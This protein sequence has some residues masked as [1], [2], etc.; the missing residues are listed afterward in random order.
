MTGRVTHFEIPSKEPLKAAKF[1][2]DVFGWD[3]KQMGK[4]EYW[5]VDT[6]HGSKPGIDGGIAPH[7]DLFAKVSSYVCTIEVENLDETAKLIIKAG[8]KAA[9]SGGLIHGV[10]FHQ[11]FKDTE[12][13]LIGVLEPNPNAKTV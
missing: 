3:S 11:Y 6:K 2:K 8:G 9:N 4:M 5:V 7:E 1:Y 12:E 13:N 10:G